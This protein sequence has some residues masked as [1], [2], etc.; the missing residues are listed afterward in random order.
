MF[1]GF[2]QQ[3]WVKDEKAAEQ[4]QRYLASLDQLG[5]DTTQFRYR[6]WEGLISLLI[7]ITTFKTFNTSNRQR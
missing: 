4:I 6:S 3:W 5:L 7:K 1:Q 2:V